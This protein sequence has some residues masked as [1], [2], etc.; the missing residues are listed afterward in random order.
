MGLT[1]REHTHRALVGQL[2]E[3]RIRH[4]RTSHEVQRRRIRHITT[5][6]QRRE[7]FPVGRTVVKFNIAADAPSGTPPRPAICTSTN[8]PEP[9]APPPNDSPS[10]VGSAAS[11]RVSNNRAGD[12]PIRSG[13]SVGGTTT[14]G[15]VTSAPADCAELP[16]AFVATTLTVYVVSRQTGNRARQRT[17][18]RTPRRS[19]RRRHRIPRDRR[20]PSLT[21]SRPGD[22]HR[23]VT[24]RSDHRRHTRRHTR[25]CCRY[26]NRPWVDCTEPHS[27]VRNGSMVSLRTI[28]P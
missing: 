10:T 11:A 13:P 22:D 2:H 8:A 12:T 28:S 6:I 20:I 4:I 18:R 27:C 26:Y 24:R 3:R 21:G 15:V 25:H 14:G 17:R 23:G 5:R 7:P 19:R 9:T 16:T 1:R